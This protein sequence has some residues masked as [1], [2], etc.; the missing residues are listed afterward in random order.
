MSQERMRD[1]R[2]LDRVVPFALERD[3]LRVLA[4]D[5]PNA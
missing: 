4:N 3:E 5:L 2:A 1:L